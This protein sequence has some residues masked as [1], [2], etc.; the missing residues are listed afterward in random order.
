MSPVIVEH[1]IIINGI[2]VLSFYVKTAA[3]PLP[4]PP[5]LMLS[6]RRRLFIV[7]VALGDNASRLSRKGWV[8]RGNPGRTVGRERDDHHVTP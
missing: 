5:L 1:N 6:C 4:P 7:F 3:A 2:L 8:V